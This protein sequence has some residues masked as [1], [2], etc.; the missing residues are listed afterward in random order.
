MNAR[1][2]GWYLITSRWGDPELGYWDADE[3]T[4]RN[5]R[6]ESDTLMS[7]AR[8]A[9]RVADGQGRPLI[10]DEEREA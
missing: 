8:V 4:W 9:G 5:D 7:D 10:R 2:P 6:G 1:K 3:D